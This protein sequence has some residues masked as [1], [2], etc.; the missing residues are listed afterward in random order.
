MGAAKSLVE[1]GALF[2]PSAD[3]FDHDQD[4]HTVQFYSQDSALLN[5]L[6]RFIGAALNN[7]SSVLI[8]ATQ[9]HREELAQ[10]LEAEGFDLAS[11]LEQ[12]RYLAL[13]AAETLAKFVVDGAPD[14]P[15][16]VRT[17]TPH[18]AKLREAAGGE[19]PRVAA[20]GEM[21]SLLWAEGKPE[22]AIQLEK[23]WNRLAHINGF[24]LRCAYPLKAFDRDEHSESFLK[25]CG[26][27]SG[28]IP[29]EDYSDL[30]QDTERLRNIS[31]LQQKAQAL[32]T[33]RAERRKIQ[34]SLHQS[35][36]ALAD[37]LE[38]ALEGV[39]QVGPDHKVLWANKA[40]LNLLGYS[41]N[42]Y[43]NRDLAEFHVNPEVFQVF[44]RKLMRREDVYDFPADLRCKDG[45]AKQ[46]LINSNVLWQQGKFTHTRC[47]IRDITEQKRMEQELRE[48]EARLQQAKDELERQVEQ[49]TVALRR[50]SSQVLS[51]QDSE[52][53]RIARG[54]HD[55]LGQYL[56]GLKLNVDLLRQHP[57][58]EE[59]WSDSEQLL[60]HCITEIRT[61]SYLLHPPMMD[62]VGLASAVRWYAEGL[63]QRSGITV[64]LEIPARLARLSHATEIALFRMLQEAL[65]NVHRH[66]GA[67]VANVCIQQDAEQ[68]VL[69]VRDNGHGMK[70]ELL[71]SFNQ[72]GTGV[73][74]GL[75]GMRERVWELGGKLKLQ[76]NEK[77][78]SM[79]ITVPLPQ[80]N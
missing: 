55:S 28:V 18:L 51:L 8:I 4:G 39:Q 23:F 35:E 54:L 31:H 7:R 30:I 41:A 24:A 32:E 61:L 66:S 13:D 38:N 58:R 75:A 79:E 74:V 33:E 76:S 12:G 3:R 19:I 48:N 70:Q 37:F 64:N 5:S 25:I 43:V 10:K 77:G 72:T 53:R 71:N 34:R 59:L 49:R 69:E 14:E 44:W 20:F 21:V 52:R 17:L 36:A 6:S 46:V 29:G 80:S 40:L 26:E 11:V 27:H 62:E 15:T 56:A 9:S 67:S 60:E 78:T 73:G 1:V 63:A 45:S 16:F 65:T 68:V 22:A 42:E 47:F 57:D 2:V 50:L